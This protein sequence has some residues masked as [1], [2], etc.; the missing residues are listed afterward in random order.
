MIKLILSETKAMGISTFVDLFVMISK[1]IQ[2]PIEALEEIKKNKTKTQ[3]IFSKANDAIMY[4]PLITTNA[5]SIQDLI[6]VSKALERQYATF[7]RLAMGLENVIDNKNITSIGSFV[8]KFHTNMKAN[9]SK[10]ILISDDMKIYNY[11]N[12]KKSLQDVLNETNNNVSNIK[13]RVNANFNKIM[14]STSSRIQQ[15]QGQFTTTGQNNRNTT[16]NKNNVG[17]LNIKNNNFLDKHVK[18][19]LRDNDVRKSNELIPTTFS[20]SVNVKGEKY[21]LE[22]LLGVKVTAH[23][24]ESGSMVDNIESIILGN[25]TSFRLMQWYTGEIKFFRDFLFM[26]NEMKKNAISNSTKKNAWW[27]ALKD[28]ATS[29]NLRSVNFLKNDKLLPNSTLLLTMDEID[30]IKNKTNINLLEDYE[31]MDTIVRQLFLL[32]VVVIDSSIEIVYFYFDGRNEWEKYAFRQ[33]EKDD[34]NTRLNNEILLSV[35][36]NR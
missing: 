2:N 16:N 5:V 1:I 18:T 31:I 33:L 24:V 26:V 21:T 13:N 3:S 22:A 32:G 34:S 7:L 6:M 17:N 8:K 9:V 10:N 29:A 30:E 27:R 4:F 20:I 11:N 35:L 23:L 28:R 25:R 15:P 12:N 36:R 19:E 14:N